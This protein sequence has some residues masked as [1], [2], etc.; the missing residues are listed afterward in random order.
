MIQS[1]TLLYGR[2]VFVFVLVRCRGGGWSPRSRQSDQPVSLPARSCLV[3]HM[4][5]YQLFLKNDHSYFNVEYN[6]FLHSRACVVSVPWSGRGRGGSVAVSSSRLPSPAHRGPSHGEATEMTT[7]R[8]TWERSS[9][10]THA[11]THTGTRARS[12]A[13]RCAGATW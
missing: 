3:S 8:V 7:A 1:F 12:V 2:K 6:S 4:H 9:G 5:Y 11:L 10:N 13:S